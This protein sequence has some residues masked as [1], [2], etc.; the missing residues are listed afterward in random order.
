LAITI[1]A[2]IGKSALIIV[3]MQND[4]IHPEGGF[5]HLAQETP[6][7]KID[8]PFLMGRPCQVYVLGTRR[9]CILGRNCAGIQTSL[10]PCFPLR[11]FNLT[12][13]TAAKIPASAVAS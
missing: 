6:E 5:A 4:F 9:G 7:A 8:M 10:P 11:L 12:K 2:E 3:D 13:P 1:G